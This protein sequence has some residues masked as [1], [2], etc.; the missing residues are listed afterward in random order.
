MVESE[1]QARH[2]ISVPEIKKKFGLKGKFKSFS[3]P[4]KQNADSIDKKKLLIIMDTG[5]TNG[6]LRRKNE[7]SGKKAQIPDGRTSICKRKQ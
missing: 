1:Y 3:V 7:V 6:N 2:W 5:G 4:P